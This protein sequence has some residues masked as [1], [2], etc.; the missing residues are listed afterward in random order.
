[1][2]NDV[3]RLRIICY[4]CHE[5]QDYLNFQCIRFQYLDAMTALIHV[6]LEVCF[7]VAYYFT[8]IYYFYIV[9][10]GLFKLNVELL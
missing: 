4:E 6:C 2:E 8:K 5:S 10:F 3:Y 7:G 1:M 9:F